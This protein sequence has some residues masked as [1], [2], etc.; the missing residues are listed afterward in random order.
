MFAGKIGT[1]CILELINEKGGK[2]A[3]RALIEHAANRLKRDKY[4][5][6]T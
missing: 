3:A 2:D 6:M 4:G 5:N 1:M